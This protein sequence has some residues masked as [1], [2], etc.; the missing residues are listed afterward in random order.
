MLPSL[1][2]AVATTWS[3]VACRS[4]EETIAI[5][6]LTGSENVTLVSN[7][8]AAKP[9]LAFIRTEDETPIAADFD[10]F[11]W[12]IEPDHDTAT[13]ELKRHKRRGGI[14]P[15]PDG[16]VIVWWLIDSPPE[17]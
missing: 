3:P 5:L 7:G 15:T 4:A 12:K 6:R 14:M 2:L 11:R 10:P 13:A 9:F 8:F 16:K 1:L 17:R